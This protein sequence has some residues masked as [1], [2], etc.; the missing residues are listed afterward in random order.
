M[1]TRVSVIRSSKRFITFVHYYY[2]TRFTLNHYVSCSLGC[3]RVVAFVRKSIKPRNHATHTPH[4]DRVRMALRYRCDPARGGRTTCLRSIPPRGF[5]VDTRIQSRK[6]IFHSKRRKRNY[7]Y[8]LNR[9]RCNVVTTKSECLNY[10]TG[11]ELLQRRDPYCR[12]N[13][14]TRNTDRTG[15]NNYVIRNHHATTGGN[16]RTSNA[17]I[18]DAF[19]SD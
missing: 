19:P 13:S 14:N 18:F 9:R 17:I 5:V 4:D 3:V 2:E 16:V 15:T 1:C 11:S 7:T 10:A 8:V 12:N 6:R